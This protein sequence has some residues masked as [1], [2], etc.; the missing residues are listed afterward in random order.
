MS[1]VEV[2][3]VYYKKWGM[4]KLV[5]R[6]VKKGVRRDKK[7]AMQPRN[8]YAM[9]VHMSQNLAGKTTH[10]TERLINY[11]QSRLAES[12]AVSSSTPLAP[13]TTVYPTSS[14]PPC[15]ASPPLLRDSSPNPSAAASTQLGNPAGC[16]LN[17]KGPPLSPAGF[18]KFLLLSIDVKFYPY[19]Y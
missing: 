19:F 2:I 4:E 7:Y 10:K 3:R 12:P 11:F 6:D 5:H 9:G 18:P 1:A 13:R 17:V 14:T 15:A 8:W 16:H